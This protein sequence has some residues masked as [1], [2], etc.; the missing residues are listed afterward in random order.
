MASGVA[1]AVASLP[2]RRC[3]VMDLGCVLPESLA[4]FKT[5]AGELRYDVLII[6]AVRAL[7]EEGRE[8]IQ[9]RL[10]RGAT[11]LLEYVSGAGI[12]QSAYFPYVEYFWPLRVKI[13]EF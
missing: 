13:R 8:I 6:P 11:V 12:Q 9:S 4:G 10:A 7:S 5:W 2:V 1:P 3:E